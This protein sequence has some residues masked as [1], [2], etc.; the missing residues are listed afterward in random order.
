MIIK[1]VLSAN[2]SMD[3]YAVGANV[4]LDSFLK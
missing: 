4:A 1:G 2:L 3:D